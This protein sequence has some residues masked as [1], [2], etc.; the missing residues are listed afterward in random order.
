MPNIEIYTMLN[1]LGMC[2]FTCHAYTCIT[3]GQYY[4]LYLILVRLV[5]AHIL[6]DIL[7]LWL[8]LQAA[9]RPSPGSKNDW[10][11][12][13]YPYNLVSSYLLVSRHQFGSLFTSIVDAYSLSFISTFYDIWWSVRL[14]YVN[15]GQC[16][17]TFFVCEG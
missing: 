14:L 7:F 9:S 4:A 5:M 3:H 11:T 17:C 13:F 10:Y 2:L 8:L 16:M 1:K 12:K 6:P 15:L